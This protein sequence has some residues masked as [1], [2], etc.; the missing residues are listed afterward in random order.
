[1]ICG[2]LVF[3]CYFSK[4]FFTMKNFKQTLTPLFFV[5]AHLMTLN[6]Q[7]DFQINHFPQDMQLF[8]RNV[9]TNKG[10]YTID[11]A[12]PKGSII[13]LVKVKIFRGDALVDEKSQL[14]NAASAAVP[15]ALTFDIKAELTEYRIELRKTVL[16]KD[17]LVKKADKLVAGDVFLVNGQSN[18]IG[19]I[20][21]NDYSPFIR[22][23][24]A[25]FGWNDIKYTQPS[26]WAPRLAKMI[27]DQQK[28]PVAIFNESYGGV[29][30]SYFLKTNATL[31]E[32]NYVSSL[33]R[34]EA[35]E[36]K[37][38]LRAILWWQGESDGWETPAETF[39]QQFKQLHA[40]WMKDYNNPQCYVFQIRFKSCAHTNPLIMEVQRQLASELPNLENISTTSALSD[41]CH[42]AYKN[43]YDSLGN[44]LFRLV[45]A[46]N[47]GTSAAY[48]RSPDVERAWFTNKTEI[49][50]L[51]KNTNALKLMGNPWADFE[52]NG[53]NA[54][55]TEGVIEGNLIKLRLT[56]D[57]TGVRGISYLGH[58]SPQ[59]NWI[60][61][62][63]GMGIMT[64]SNFPITTK[65]PSTSV[66]TVVSNLF[67]VYPT[68]ADDYLN[69]RLL[70]STATT[71]KI[72]L[73]STTGVLQ[74]EQNLP[75]DNANTTLD[76]SKIPAG[77]YIVVLSQ[78][79]QKQSVK[80]IV[81]M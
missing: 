11:G 66:D 6:A 27:I 7:S 61:N 3:Y 31:S 57:T 9:T 19:S 77:L 79:N 48:T 21:D 17:S 13:T 56:G 43:G 36:V 30:Q 45:S 22:S 64:F 29:R 54:K 41:G 65:P 51:I 32:N 25:Q 58:I 20:E 39:K 63:L 69:I 44:R 8:P 73:F 50:I 33:K 5:F 67:E 55:I 15:F 62:P 76:V 60:T 34:L 1:M 71:K 23:H 53:G 16:G 2:I 75:F 80:K 10:G 40:D 4:L 42:F 49:N 35:A 37:N 52:I 14:I 46:R 24:T 12:I 72:A 59:D 26:K 70:D 28:I 47:Y 68:L 18:N 74:F 81:K 38:N 78:G